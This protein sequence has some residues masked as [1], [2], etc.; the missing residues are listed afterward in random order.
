MEQPVIIRLGEPTTTGLAPAA[1]PPVQWKILDGE[2]IVAEGAAGE[3]LV[4]WPADLPAGVYQLQLT[5]LSSSYREQVPLIVAPA[6]AFQGHFERSWILA[7]QLY[8]IRSARNWG[9]GDF[10]DLMQLI[11]LTASWGGDGVGLNPLHALFPERPADCSPYSPNSRLFLN[12]LYIDIDR[13][14]E[15][16]GGLSADDQEALAR[17]RRSLWSITSR[18]RT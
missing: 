13:I 9:I 8:G 14:P 1:V 3:R 15:F 5:E 2:A 11:E 10:T 16:S 6:K 12:P 4:R 18:L 7:V 17:A